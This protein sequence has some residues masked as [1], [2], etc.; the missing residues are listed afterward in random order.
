[1]SFDVVLLILCIVRVA[2]PGCQKTGM[3]LTISDTGLLSFVRE[4]GWLGTS[5][6]HKGAF[7]DSLICFLFCNVDLLTCKSL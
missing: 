7:I 3:Q 4:K 6:P 1:M 5:L 2:S